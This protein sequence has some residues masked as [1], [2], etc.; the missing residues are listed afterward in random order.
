MKKNRKL[1]L[2][3]AIII[4]MSMPS[5]SGVFAKTILIENETMFENQ[6]KS[7]KTIWKYRIYKGEKQKR[8]WSI[9]YKRWKTEWLTY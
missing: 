7:E 2:I 5:D 3:L 6:V 1:I 8:L 9:T 4:C